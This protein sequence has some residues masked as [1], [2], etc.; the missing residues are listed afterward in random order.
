MDR[1]SGELVAGTGDD[2]VLKNAEKEVLRLKAD[3]SFAIDGR[4]IEGNDQVVSA[5]RHWLTGSAEAL[6][7][8]AESQG[9]ILTVTPPKPPTLPP[10][11]RTKAAH[12]A[13]KAALRD[14]E[15]TKR[16]AGRALEE[17]LETF[18]LTMK[19]IVV[20]LGATVKNLAN[21]KERLST[22]FDV[23][24]FVNTLAIEGIFGLE[25]NT[26]ALI[27]YYTGTRKH[28]S[29]AELATYL[30]DHHPNLDIEAALNKI[31]ADVEAASEKI[32]KALTA[33]NRT[34]LVAT[35]LNAKLKQEAAW[36]AKALPGEAP[37]K[38]LMGGGPAPKALT[39]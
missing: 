21:E 35:S 33:M 37:P 18:Y 5:L 27:T 25:L 10:L 15:A 16:N 3:G 9:R 14:R 7:V 24:G 38:E 17:L 4:P 30:L 19:P 1:W 23:G 13:L 32:T 34:G 28:A 8:P 22:A 20:E 11:T 6:P 29:P 26:G 39:G 31:S 12:E 2:I 36:L